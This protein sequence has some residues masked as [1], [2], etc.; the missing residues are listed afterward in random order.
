MVISEASPRAPASL[1]FGSVS[2]IV[3]LGLASLF[4]ARAA[5]ADEVRLENGDVIRG[6]VTGADEKNVKIEHVYGQEIVLP[7]AKVVSIET[8]EPVV[9]RLVDGTELKGKLEPGPERGTIAVET[10][11]AGR[12][13]R[14]ERA[15]V[16]G[17]G[18]LSGAVWTGRIALGVTITDGNTQSKGVFA[19]FDAERRAKQD[20]IE[21]HAFFNYTE[22]F[23]DVTARRGFARG[24]YSYRI[25]NPLYFYVGGALEN[26]KQRDLKLRSRGGGGIS[27]AWL[28]EPDLALRTE[29]GV[30]YVNE[31]RKRGKDGSFVALRAALTF[32]WKITKWL[33]FREFDEIFP[34][35]EDFR[36]FV[37]R[38]ETSLAF[39]MW[40]GFGLAF[41]VIWD[42]D[43]R[44]PEGRERND[45]QYMATLT[46]AF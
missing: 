13:A 18:E 16:A 8:D 42:Y 23:G 44:P 19:S 5:T 15:S 30:D 20:L 12:I 36:K 37:N 35:T 41:V 4:A 9:L 10:A 39:S 3:A 43:S 27:C 7:L 40:K 6:K 29:G 17:I 26:D 21:A 22:T 1:R 25:W 11:G 28:D 33:S 32:H 46:Y 2:R 14:V 38:S 45:E 24:E 34:S 31:D